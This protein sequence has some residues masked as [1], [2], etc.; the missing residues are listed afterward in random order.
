M[1]LIVFERYEF[2]YIMCWVFLQIY[3][4]Y[5]CMCLCMNSDAFIWMIYIV[6]LKIHVNGMFSCIFMC[7]RLFTKAA[8]HVR[9]MYIFFA[10][11]Y[12]VKY[13]A[14]RKISYVELIKARN[15]AHIYIPLYKCRSVKYIK[16]SRFRY[17]SK[18]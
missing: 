13:V 8:A 7:H 10:L 4:I 3:F 9:V 1:N 16:F 18:R 5:V 12:Y 6:I 15:S 14:P 17:D 11:F 2:L